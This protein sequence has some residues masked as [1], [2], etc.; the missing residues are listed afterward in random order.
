MPVLDHEV[1]PSTQIGK[2][3]RHGCWNLSRNFTGY[4]AQDGWE[5]L[6][7]DA[8]GMPRISQPK[9][10]WIHHNMS[11][12]CRNDFSLTDPFCKGCEW[13]GTGEAYDKM[14]KEQGR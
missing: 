10:V 3:Y 4:W 5:F 13:V 14:V 8:D 9:W 6:D 2:D 1:H 11:T 12:E 7:R